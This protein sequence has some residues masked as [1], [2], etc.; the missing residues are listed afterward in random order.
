MK[1]LIIA[2]LVSLTILAF[3]GCSPVKFYSNPGLTQ[4][5]GLKYYTVK[6]YLQVEKDLS[7]GNIVKAT[8]VY[9]PDLMNPQYM[10]LRDGLG[11]RKVDIKLTDGA[12]STFGVA[13][14]PKIAESIDA[15]A[16]LI[17]KSSAAIAD[18]TTLKGV[19]NM[20]APATVT[21]LYEVFMGPEGTTV[22]KIEFK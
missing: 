4:N 18:L 14:D 17:S 1:N 16:G 11:S 19:P 21:E 10:V 22:K 13:T 2:A 15:L 9:L 7:S 12:I 3:T 20:A 8:V 6:P 5:T